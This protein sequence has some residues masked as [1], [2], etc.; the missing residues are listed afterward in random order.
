MIVVDDCWAGRDHIYRNLPGKYDSAL[1]AYREF[2]AH[3]GLCERVVE[4]K[5]GI[6]RKQ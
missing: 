2:L 1:D 3:N 4:K 5:P 6:V